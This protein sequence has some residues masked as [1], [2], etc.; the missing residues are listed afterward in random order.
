VATTALAMESTFTQAR[1]AGITDILTKPYTPDQLLQVLNK[2]LNDDETELIMEDSTNFSGFE[3]HNEL[4][5]KY[6]NALYENNISYAAD[7][8]EIFLKTIRE[9]VVKL[10]KLVENRDWEQLKFQVHKLKPNFA[11]VGLTWITHKMQQ[12]ENTLNSNAHTP[13]EQVD[14]VFAGI[15]RDLDKFYPIIEQEYERMKELL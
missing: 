1:Q 3:F 10:R 4:D 13:P 7:L 12:L 15:S 2:Y 6:L 14:D 9:E 11:M 5:V 8:F